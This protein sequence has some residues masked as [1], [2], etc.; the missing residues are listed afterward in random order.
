MDNFTLP[1]FTEAKKLFL[2]L[3]CGV[4]HGG[5]TSKSVIN[6]FRKLFLSVIFVPAFHARMG[7]LK[8]CTPKYGE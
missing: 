7:G 3:K 6:G 5:R 4:S 8:Y 2:G 1:V